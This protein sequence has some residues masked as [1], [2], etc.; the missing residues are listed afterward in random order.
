MVHVTLGTVVA[1]GSLIGLLVVVA[2]I[3]GAA[4][5]TSRNVQTIT[6]YRDAAQSWEARAN[7]QEQELADQQ[8]QITNQ[9]TQIEGLTKQLADKDRQLD[10]LQEQIVSLRELL[11]GRAEFASLQGQIDQLLQMG[12]TNQANIATLMHPEGDHD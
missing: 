11:S 5:R 3:L 2:G 9:Q 10:M 1:V 4:F 6:N 7:A 12:R 8:H